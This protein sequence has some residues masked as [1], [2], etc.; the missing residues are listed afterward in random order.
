[1][2]FIGSNDSYGAERQ[3]LNAERFVDKAIEVD[4]AF[5]LGVKGMLPVQTSRR[6]KGGFKTVYAFPFAEGEADQS[7]ELAHEL[8][9]A[10]DF[11][12]LLLSEARELSGYEF[13]QIGA[14]YLGISAKGY[15]FTRVEVIACEEDGSPAVAPV[16]LRL[17]TSDHPGEP[18]SLSATVEYDPEGYVHHVLMA[19]TSEDGRCLRAMATYDFREH[20]IFVS[21]VTETPAYGGEPEELY[22]RYPKRKPRNNNPSYEDEGYWD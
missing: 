21:R 8:S 7:D 5:P 18:G 10:T 20:D 4:A 3:E 12:N 22:R 13:G 6:K 17:E 9:E 2:N 16:H 14:L 19:E 15:G 11:V 1:M